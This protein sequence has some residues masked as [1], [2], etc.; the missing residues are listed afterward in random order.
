MDTL[1]LCWASNI[2]DM[3]IY[4]VDRNVILKKL[5][6]KTWTIKNGWSYF[7]ENSDIRVSRSKP[8]TLSRLSRYHVCSNKKWTEET[9]DMK[10]KHTKQYWS[11]VGGWY[12]YLLQL[13]LR[14]QQNWLFYN[15]FLSPWK[16]KECPHKVFRGKG[17]S[18][19]VCLSVNGKNWNVYVWK[20]LS[21]TW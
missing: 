13:K 6:L 1:L 14:N 3:I 15:I 16:K 4:P 17:S 10:K 18:L 21:L 5:W 20:Y 12:R 8:F 7:W 19:S 9:N 2:L 11:N